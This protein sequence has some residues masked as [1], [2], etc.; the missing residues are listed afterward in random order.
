MSSLFSKLKKEDLRP[1]KIINKHVAETS[2]S[3][4]QVIKPLGAGGFGMVKLVQV[5]GVKDRAFALK[6][7]SEIFLNTFFL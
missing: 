3:K 7:G 5:E 6:L 1:T 2:L 4:L